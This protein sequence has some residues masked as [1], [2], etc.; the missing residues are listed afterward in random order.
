MAHTK[1]KAMVPGA[2]GKKPQ[3]CSAANKVSK[4]AGD[5][6]FLLHGSNLG[7]WPIASAAK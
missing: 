5:G 6:S 4:R 7:K 3:Q 1:V 2:L